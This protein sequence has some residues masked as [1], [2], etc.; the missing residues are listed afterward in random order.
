MRESGKQ[1]EH[2]TVR[3]FVHAKGIAEM[4]GHDV[5]RGKGKKGT[6]VVKG[7]KDFF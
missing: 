3:S 7:I 4:Q 5:A 2:K 6:K 1:R